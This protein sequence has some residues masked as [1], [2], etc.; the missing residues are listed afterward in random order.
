LTRILYGKLRVFKNKN[1]SS[2]YQLEN[3]TDVKNYNFRNTIRKKDNFLSTKITT[4]KQNEN[5]N[6]VNNNTRK[7]NENTQKLA[8]PYKIKQLFP[9]SKNKE[10]LHNRYNSHQ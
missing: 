5:N 10:T 9:L 3:Q 1:F 2:S 6:I 8:S 7:N 4:S